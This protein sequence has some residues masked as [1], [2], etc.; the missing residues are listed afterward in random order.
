MAVNTWARQ[1]RQHQGEMTSLQTRPIPGRPACLSAEQWQGVLAVLEAGSL[2]TGFDT[3]RW[4]LLHICAVLLVTFWVRYHALYL[5][6]R[7]KALSWGA[8]QPAVYARERD[9]ALVQAWLPHDW[10]RIKKGSA[11]E[12]GEHVRR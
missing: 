1:L 5:A 12:S 11:P 6:S 7:L 8:Q 9:D 2:K 4:T 3:D 10:L